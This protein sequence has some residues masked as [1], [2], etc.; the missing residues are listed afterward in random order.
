MACNE[1]G[2]SLE[3]RQ[4]LRAD[5]LVGC[6]AEGLAPIIEDGKE[7]MHKPKAEKTRKLEENKEP[8]RIKSGQLDVV[9]ANLD[10]LSQ[11]VRLPANAGPEILRVLMC[12]RDEALRA[13]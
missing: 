5:E 4:R 11:D 1:K 7:I 13:E 2:L 12:R 8:N 10:N 9:E 6:H 3:E